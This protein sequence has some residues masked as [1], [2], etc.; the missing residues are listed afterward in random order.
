MTA[1]PVLFVPAHSVVFSLH[2]QLEGFGGRWPQM[3]GRASRFDG[4]IAHPQEAH[5]VNV[6]L[7]AK[8]EDSCVFPPRDVLDR[9]DFFVEFAPQDT[10]QRVLFG[11]V[12]E[13]GQLETE[14]VAEIRFDLNSVIGLPVLET[15]A[16]LS[17]WL[18]SAPAD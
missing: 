1:F 12:G 11:L 6:I 16:L 14:V 13:D 17:A 4:E 7:E 9:P 8:V 18:V 3:D 10:Q 2:Q 15:G 5:R